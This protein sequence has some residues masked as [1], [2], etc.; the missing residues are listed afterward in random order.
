MLN[1]NTILIDFDSINDLVKYLNE[2][3][4]N[5]W[6]K[7]NVSSKAVSDWYKRFSSTN[8][9]E[10]AKNM[11]EFGWVD[12]SKE[13]NKKFNMINKAD[14][15]KKQVK[16]IED[17]AGFQPIVPN[18]LIGIP[19]SMIRSKIVMQKQKVVTIN[20][21]LPFSSYASAEN[22]ERACLFNLLAIK[23]IEN[24][25]VRVNFNI[26]TATK[27]NGKTGII[28]LKVK[29]ANERLNISKIC[30]PATNPSYLRRIMFRVI[31]TNKFYDSSFV[32]G[33]GSPVKDEELVN[34]IKLKSSGEYLIPSGIELTGK[35]RQ[36]ENLMKI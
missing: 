6:F 2:A 34:L 13:I 27:K 10:E 36:L 11:L 18:Y 23:C 21:Q 20:A 8:S 28:R 14:F 3:K 5:F 26:I 31:E 22:M 25:G 15:T 32:I 29:N 17:V 30:F 33:Y 9:F 35:D 4:T 7:N 16:F 24:S 1:K 12:K 19:N